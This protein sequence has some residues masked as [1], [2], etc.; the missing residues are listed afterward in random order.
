MSK[1]AECGQ[2]RPADRSTK[3]HR[4]LFGLISAAFHQWPEANDFQP[5]DSEQLRSWLLCKA[6]FCEKTPIECPDA[7]AMP[8]IAQLIALACES[9][10]RAANGRGFIRVHGD[11]I[12]VFTPRSIAWDKLDQKAFNDIRDRVTGV[13]ES[14]LNIKAETLL[15]EF[16]EMA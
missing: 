8:G 5:E 10:M 4:R 12:V 6:G 9:V 11:R 16:Q 15:K 3:D 14:E 7:D 2:Q 1:C 13:I